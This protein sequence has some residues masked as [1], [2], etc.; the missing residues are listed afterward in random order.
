M[1][2]NVRPIRPEETTQFLDW[3]HANREKNQYDPDTFKKKQA[4]IYVAY[5][6]NG[7]ICYFPFEAVL[8]LGSLAPR[9]DATDL[10]RAKAILAMHTVLVTKCH[11]KNIGG[12][13]LAGKDENIQSALK[14]HLHW[15]DVVDPIIG[16]KIAD[17]EKPE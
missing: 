5:D 7:P 12:M 10:E 6:E 3:L 17:L 8:M 14:D 9:P 4:E 1:A 13:L 11:E 16:L 15:K 2:V